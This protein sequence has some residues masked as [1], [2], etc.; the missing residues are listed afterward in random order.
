MGCGLKQTID[1]CK[2]VMPMVR[3]AV[4]FFKQY[5]DLDTTNV[6]NCNALSDFQCVTKYLQRMKSQ[7]FCP[8]KCLPACAELR[9]K[10][11]IT[12]LALKG[13]NVSCG[14]KACEESK[15]R[16]MVNFYISSMLAEYMEENQAYN[17]LDLILNIGGAINAF[18]GISFLSVLEIVFFLCSVIHRATNRLITSGW[19]KAK[20][21]VS[22][23]YENVKSRVKAKPQIEPR[24]IKPKYASKATGTDAS[25]NIWNEINAYNDF[26]KRIN[27]QTTSV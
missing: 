26:R 20:R 5:I 7:N 12:S 25:M 9:Y 8:Y 3:T 19:P 23:F 6:K 15:N 14:T 17:M 13:R 10:T 24:K 11:S 22:N 18:F 2:C 1:T 16:I 27:R 4:E 21:F